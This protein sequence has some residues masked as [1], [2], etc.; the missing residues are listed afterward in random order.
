[1]LDSVV[2]RRCGDSGWRKGVFAGLPEYGKQLPWLISSPSSPDT[3]YS[4]VKVSYEGLSL[5]L[6]FRIDDGGMS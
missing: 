5:N 3:L 2:Y 1:M 4:A 6:V